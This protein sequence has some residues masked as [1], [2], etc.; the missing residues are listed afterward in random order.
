[1]KEPSATLDAPSSSTGNA[2]EFTTPKTTSKSSPNTLLVGLDLGTNTSCLLAETAGNKNISVSK[3]VPTV[4]G[5]PKEGLVEGIITNNAKILF[6]EAALS[7]RQQVKLVAPLE[8][9]IIAHQQPTA[10]FLAHLRELADPSGRAEIRAVIGVPAN[11]GDEAR[12]DLC[13]AITG[14]F[15]R[16]LLVPEPFLAAL[17]YRDDSRIGQS[18]YVDP[19]ANSLFVDIGGGTTDLCLVQGYFPEARDQISIPFA[20]DA[21]DA[22]LAENIDRIYPNSGMSPLDVRK[23][24]EDQAYVGPVRRPLD[25]EVIVGGKARTLDLGESVGNACNTLFDKIYAGVR[26]LIAR[27]PSDAVATTLQNIIVTGGGSRIKGIDT[28]LQQRLTDDGYVSPKVR[29]AG[30][31]YKRFVALG[32]LKAARS[33]AENQWQH[34]IT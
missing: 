31:D 13:Q 3:I 21:V 9:G 25:T 17:G 16:V 23:V 6:G 20:G 5:Y 10:D 14:I 18:N 26:R 8:H 11:A 30:V 12:E 19:V 15:Q 1:M 29:L 2:S 32:A 22:L 4:V 7:L 27:A 24:K 34:L 28:V 33:T